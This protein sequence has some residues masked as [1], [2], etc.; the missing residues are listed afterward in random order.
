[1]TLTL[2][3]C[4]VPVHFLIF[5]MAALLYHMTDQKQRTLIWCLLLPVEKWKNCH[6]LV[7][8]RQ[9]FEIVFYQKV[10]LHNDHW[11]FLLT[12]D[13]MNLLIRVKVIQIYCRVHMLFS[14]LFLFRTLKYQGIIIPLPHLYW[15]LTGH[16]FHRI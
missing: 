7:G 13:C 16:L 6:K 1:M 9:P 3:F 8:W 15:Y 10:V 14:T 12:I 4:L 2:F 11:C 5:S